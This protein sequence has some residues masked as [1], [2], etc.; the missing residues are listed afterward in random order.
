MERPIE[1]TS[2]S[3]GSSK[4]D[5]EFTTSLLGDMFHVKRIGTDGDKMKAIQL[6][7]ELDGKGNVAI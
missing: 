2:V 4:R 5:H 3:I 6:I 1:I 7:R